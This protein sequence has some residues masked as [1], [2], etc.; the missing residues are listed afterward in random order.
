MTTGQLPARLPVTLALVAAVT[1]V[2]TWVVPAG[3]GQRVYGDAAQFAAGAIAA[4]ACF[5]AAR[6]HAGTRALWRLL[7]GAALVSWALVRLW[8]TVC[9]LVEP[10]HAPAV[11]VA[12]VGLLTLPV[13]TFVALV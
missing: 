7:L 4:G 6:G 11:T 13:L 1:A 10:G 3:T 9:V 2:G 8:W 12:D 5:A